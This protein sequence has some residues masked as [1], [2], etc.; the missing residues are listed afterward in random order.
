M[1]VAAVTLVKNNFG[2]NPAQAA[3][4][5]LHTITTQGN[6]FA[7]IAAHLIS[8][9]NGE[10]D[11]Q[12]PRALSVENPFTT[13]TRVGS[14]GAVVQAFMQKFADNGKGYDPREPL[15]TVMA[16]APRHAVISA[17]LEQANGSPEGEKPLAGRS[18]EDPLSTIVAKGCTQRVVTS[19]L[20]KLRGTCAHGQPVDEP[21]AT[22]SAQGTHIAEV[23]AFLLKYYGNESEGHDPERPLGTV[24]TKDR[25]GLITVTIEGEEY[26]IVDIGMRMLT[27]R[28]LF[29]AQGFPP[30][31]IIDHDAAGNPTTKTSQVARCGNSVCPPLSRALTAA[32]APSA[33]WRKPRAKARRRDGQA[34]SAGQGALA[35]AS[36]RSEAAPS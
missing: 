23:R 22:V 2:A 17:H 8:T 16:G 33:G 14:Q 34:L 13:V 20:V 25:F 19:N 29:N 35:A 3:G 28:E 1:R 26:V 9:R 7:L 32:N 24:T 21:L 11:G 36:D 6:R 12:A 18:A 5:P 10:R 15:H 31:Y 30:D 4:A 27:P